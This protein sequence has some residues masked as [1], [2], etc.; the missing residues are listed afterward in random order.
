MAEAAAVVLASDPDVAGVGSAVLGRGNAVDAV[1]ASIFGAAG[2]YPSV[3]LGPVQVLIGGAGAGLRAIDGR[4]RQPGLGN[5]RPRGFL[6]SDAIPDAARVG[7]PALPAA[8]LAA[9]TTYGKVSVAAVL[10]PGIE[11][12]RAKSKAR[13]AVL[14]RIAERGPAALAEASLADE[15]TAL[16]GRLAGGLLSAQDLDELRPVLTRASVHEGADGREVVTVPWGA[17]AIRLTQAPSLF[18][19]DV[20]VVV[21]ADRN[22]LLAVGCYEVP[23]AGLPL[24][25]FDL[26]APFHAAP[27]LRGEPRVKPGEPRGAAAPIALGQLAGTIDLA[28][29]IGASAES[30]A[31]LG[32][33][34][35]GYRAVAGLQRDEPLPTGL[36]GVQRAGATWTTLGTTG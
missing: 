24:D 18:G 23:K 34:L 3:L 5:P 30:E 27:V 32:A 25:V 14:Q 2:L 22:G 12:A 29:G 4:V 13:A 9:V 17:S 20:R 35:D 16:A 10:G 26:V 7:V 19:T 6:A 11:L 31:Q 21:A 1:I 33:W 15:L 8:L 28:T 36:L